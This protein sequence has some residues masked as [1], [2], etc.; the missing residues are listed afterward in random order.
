MIQGNGM[1]TIISAFPDSQRGKA[2]GY[3]L[4][5]VA[6]GA[7]AGPTV[8]GFLISALSWRWVFYIN[9]PIG[10]VTIL[11]FALILANERS[12][13]GAASEPRP[14]FDW[15]GAGLSGIAMLLFL[16][17]VGAALSFIQ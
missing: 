17:A 1:A 9:V 13:Q 5:V 15:A 7:I 3:H 14:S 2:L 8:G 16:L 11:V 6:S 4:S 10:I 12:A